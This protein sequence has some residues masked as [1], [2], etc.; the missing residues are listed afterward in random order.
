[1]PKWSELAI[2]TCEFTMCDL[3]VPA[4]NVLGKEGEGFKIAMSALDSGR[5]TVAA[6]AVGLM[7]ACLE[8][9]VRYAHQR[10]T[11][12]KPIAQHQLVQQMIAHMYSVSSWRN[13][14]FTK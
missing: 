4:K 6:G 9:A 3:R 1:M 2:P 7:R 11:F 8:E 10:E 12:G 5:Y 13:C 14:M